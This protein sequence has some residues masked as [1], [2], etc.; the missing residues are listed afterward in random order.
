MTEWV[1]KSFN[2][3]F[4]NIGSG[5]SYWSIGTD[6]ANATTGGLSWWKWFIGEGGI[7]VPLIVVPPKNT[8]FARADQMTNEYAFVKDVPAT[9]LDYAGVKHPGATYKDRD[10]T[11]PS[12]ISMKPFLEGGAERP[13]TEEDWVAFEL[14][15][16]TYVVAGDY[17]AMRVRPGL[18]G[19]GQWHLYEIKKDPGETTPLDELQP[20][21]LKSLISIYE[22]YAKDKGVVPVADDWNPWTSH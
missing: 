2:L 15:G 17:K 7:R 19:D 22:Q 5:S 12:G 11:A 1:K 6:F 21:R 13:R 14:F 20:E 10:L 4:D 9:I 18:F 8:K 3:E 16:N